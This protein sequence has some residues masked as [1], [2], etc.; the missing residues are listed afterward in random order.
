MA[1][2]EQLITQQ[3][4]LNVADLQRPDNRPG[5]FMAF[6]ANLSTWDLGRLL[7]SIRQMTN[8]ESR[9]YLRSIGA[10]PARTAAK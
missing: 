4:A 10:A 1:L 6:A 5:L 2:Q 9:S 3:Q 7:A 8:A